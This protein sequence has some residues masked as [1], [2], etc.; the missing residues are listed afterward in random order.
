MR[1]VRI[2]NVQNKG[3]WKIE[4]EEISNELTMPEP[5]ELDGSRNLFQAIALEFTL[6]LW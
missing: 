5:I 4:L 1:L 6:L 2:V 3:S